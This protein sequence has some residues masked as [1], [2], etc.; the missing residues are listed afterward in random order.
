MSK[1]AFA[2]FFRRHH[3]EAGQAAPA[4]VA[5]VSLESIRD[6]RNIDCESFPRQ[7]LFDNQCIL[8]LALPE[9][10]EERLPDD[11]ILPDDVRVRL[12]Y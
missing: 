6:E 4:V 3:L 10:D 11:E 5:E 9:L 12:Y 1:F 8:S 7:I 2:E